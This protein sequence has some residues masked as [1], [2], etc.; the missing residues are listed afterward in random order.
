METENIYAFQIVNVMQ[1]IEMKIYCFMYLFQLFR[2]SRRL[3]SA[4]LCLPE[5]LFDVNQ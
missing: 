1:C 3:S 4:A 5:K 2:S